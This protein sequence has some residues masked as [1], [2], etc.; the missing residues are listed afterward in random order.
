MRFRYAKLV[1]ERQ[2]EADI[3]VCRGHMVGMSRVTESKRG[4]TKMSKDL[5]CHINKPIYAG[6]NYQRIGR[7]L[8]YQ[9]LSSPE[10]SLLSSSSAPIV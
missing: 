4:H 5:S 10:L 9:S 6:D 8:D 3:A 7:M 1:Y 2:V